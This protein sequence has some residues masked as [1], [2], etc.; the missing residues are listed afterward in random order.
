[1]AFLAC[2]RACAGPARDVRP[3]QHSYAQ[4]LFSFRDRGFCSRNVIVSFCFAAEEVVIP[5]VFQESMIYLRMCGRFA[6]RARRRGL[7]A[8][9]SIINWF[10]PERLPSS[11]REW[12]LELVAGE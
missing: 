12:V 10:P 6:S 5:P 9:V 11:L 2:H 1:M 8:S 7:Q 4:L 3:P